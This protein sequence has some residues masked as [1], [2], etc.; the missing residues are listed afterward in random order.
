MSIATPA[1][2]GS[3]LLRPGGMRHDS[4][5]VETGL[6]FPPHRSKSRGR[7]GGSRPAVCSLPAASGARGA[8]STSL[9]YNIILMEGCQWRDLSL[10]FSLMQETALWTFMEAS[11]EHRKIHF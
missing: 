11:Y 10:P 2:S 4:L 8:H 5:I 9:E 1:S 3:A 7:H 6:S